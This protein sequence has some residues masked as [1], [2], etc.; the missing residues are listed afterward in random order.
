MSEENITKHHVDIT[1]QVVSCGNCGRRIQPHQARVEILNSRY[2]GFEHYHESYLGCYE[3]TRESR[4]KV[5]VQRMKPWLHHVYN[6]TSA[7]VDDGARYT[8]LIK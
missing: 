2:K 6:D 8:N 4:K 3:S 7:P 1:K 5:V